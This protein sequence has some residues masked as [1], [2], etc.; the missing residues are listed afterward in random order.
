MILWEDGN[1]PPAMAVLR[2][3][4][5]S[6]VLPAFPDESS[7]GRSPARLFD[8]SPNHQLIK[9]LLTHN[10]TDCAGGFSQQRRA[11]LPLQKIDEGICGTLMFVG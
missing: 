7:E 10:N 9:L 11:S 2:N 4:R 6:R 1:K 8:H 5:L 3:K